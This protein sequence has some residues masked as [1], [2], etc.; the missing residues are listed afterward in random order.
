M[1]SR[2]R[3][4]KPH[5]GS[6]GTAVVEHQRGRLRA[7]T[8][9]LVDEFGYDGLTV[10]A[11]VAAAG[12][13]KHTFYENFKDKDACF[14][15]TYEVIVRHAARAVLAAQSRQHE[16]R[17]RIQAGLDA[18]SSEV[19]DAP[20]AA[21]L[22]LVSA[23]GVRAASGARLRTGGLF[24]ALV[25]SSLEY[26]ADGISAPPILLRGMVAG[27]SH[28]ARARLLGEDRLLMAGTT[29]Q[30]VA[31]LLSLRGEAASEV[32]PSRATCRSIQARQA[33]RKL[34]TGHTWSQFGNERMMILSGVSQLAARDRYV[35][36]SATDIRKAAGISRRRFEMHFDGVADCYLAAIEALARD[37][38]AEAKVAFR[39]AESWPAGIYRAVSRLCEVLAEDPALLTLAFAE[40]LAW[41]GAGLRWRNTFAINVASLLDGVGPEPGR[42]MLAAE[43]SVGGLI[44]I[45]HRVAALGQCRQLPTA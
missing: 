28:V 7:A 29:E 30:M 41:E 2:Y 5:P 3:Q 23:L 27:I 37:L 9:E 12:V 43:A 20:K 13:S 32:T 10:G 18:F 1:A 8:I 24:G 4:L 35:A 11:V 36:L 38:L 33:E 42:T 45:I 39:S 14:I 6:S 25:A 44:A 21:R 40:P 31:W 34:P 16:P 15:T 22:A 17:A 26:F 19:D